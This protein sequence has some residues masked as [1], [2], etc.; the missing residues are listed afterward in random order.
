MSS[1]ITQSELQ[2]V[3]KTPI[4]LKMTPEIKPKPE[5]IRT[6]SI[7]KIKKFNSFI[8]SQNY[9]ILPSI[10]AWLKT[11]QTV[12]QQTMEKTL[13]YFKYLIISCVLFKPTDLITEKLIE[14]LKII[15]NN[16][17]QKVFIL[18]VYCS[19][20]FI[21]LQLFVCVYLLCLVFLPIGFLF[22][23]TCLYTV[24]HIY[25]RLNLS[26]LKNSERELRECNNKK[27]RQSRPKNRRNILN[28][29]TISNFNVLGC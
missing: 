2:S 10:L 4:N 26:Y 20:G 12:L 7:D 5:L 3:P 9:Y 25:Y 13:F 1:T 16:L 21:F 15:Y 28:G 27:V 18:T 8:C 6:T 29:R 17:K 11:S 14:N 19:V 22:L 24:C 23:M